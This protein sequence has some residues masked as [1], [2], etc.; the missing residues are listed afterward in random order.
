[1]VFCLILAAVVMQ[2]GF[3]PVSSRPTAATA[4]SAASTRT[5]PAVRITS[6]LGRSGTSGSIRI[7]AQVQPAEGQEVGPVRFLIDGQL[8][9]TDSDGPPYAVE[10]VDENPFDRRGHRRCPRS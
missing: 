8:F 1:M 2:A 10:W 6:P 4:T 7:V 5:T 9:R 3:S